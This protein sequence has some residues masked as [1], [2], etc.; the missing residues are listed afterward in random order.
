MR[1]HSSRRYWEFTKE[2]FLLR[3]VLVFAVSLLASGVDAIL[4]WILKFGQGVQLGQAGQTINAQLFA[5]TTY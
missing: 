2:T 5:V 4:Q 1:L 3:A